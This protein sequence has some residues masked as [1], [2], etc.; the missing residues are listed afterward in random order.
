MGF[1]FNL[2]VHYS[3]V[4]VGLLFR[5]LVARKTHSYY[6]AKLDGYVPVGTKHTNMNITYHINR[7]AVVMNRKNVN[8]LTKLH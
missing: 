4:A 5:N 2:Y 8:K 3:H 1:T 6:A 7:R